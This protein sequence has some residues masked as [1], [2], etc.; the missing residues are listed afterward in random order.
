MVQQGS[1]TTQAPVGLV[2]EARLKAS[3]VPEGAVIGVKQPITCSVAFARGQERSVQLTVHGM[4]QV[5]ICHNLYRDGCDCNRSC[6]SLV[7]RC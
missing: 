1:I 4:P 6:D 3:E 2:S 7:S 5:C